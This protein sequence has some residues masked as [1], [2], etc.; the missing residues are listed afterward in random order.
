MM[1]LVPP[2]SSRTLTFTERR[3]YAIDGVCKKKT[4]IIPLKQL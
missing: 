4:I 2:S 1:R 3:F